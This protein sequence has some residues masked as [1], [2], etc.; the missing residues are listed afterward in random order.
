M[1]TKALPFEVKV[2]T[3]KRILKGYASTFDNKDLVGDIVTKGAFK[4]TISERLDKVKALWQHQPWQPIGKP[5]VMQE[6]SKGLYVEARISKTAL[7][8]DVIEL[9]NDKVLDSFSIGYDVV[10]DDYDSQKGARYLKELKLYEFSVVTFPANELATVDGV[11]NL[12]MAQL[13]DYLRNATELD[14]KSL[15]KAGRVL[16]SGNRQLLKNAIEALENLL[17]AAEPDESEKQKATPKAKDKP[18]ENIVTGLDTKQLNEILNH[19]KL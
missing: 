15:L 7:G 4:K 13:E 14:V 5:T 1:E 16:S 12:N 10:K 3:E 18:L 9:V 11:K 2:D 8:N 6:D 19:F 17:A